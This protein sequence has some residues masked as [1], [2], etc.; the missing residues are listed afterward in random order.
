MKGKKALITGAAK[1]IGRAIACRFAEEAVDVI[2]H[3]NTSGKAVEEL[4][5]SLE[6]T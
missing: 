6:K 5:T 3:Y 4:K 2:L 1:R